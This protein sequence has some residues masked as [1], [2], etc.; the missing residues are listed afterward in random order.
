M[1][2]RDRY[3]STNQTL[4]LASLVKTFMGSKFT[5]HPERYMEILYILQ[6]YRLGDILSHLGFLQESKHTRS[7]AEEHGECAEDLAHALEDLGTC[8]IKLGQVLSTR[9]DLLPT[10]YITSLARLQDTVK[11]VPGERIAAIIERELGAPLGELFLSI[12][13]EPLATASVA[14]VHKALLHDGSQVVIKV[15][16]PEVQRQVEIDIEVMQEVAS[17]L[18]RYTPF[19]ARYGLVQIVQE[20]KQT[21]S[22]ELD[23]QQEASN[24]QLVGRCLQGFDRLKS[25]TVYLD[26]T[27]RRVL[28]LS[29]VQ[30]R[31][32]AQVSRDELKRVDSATIAQEL[33]SA[34]LKQ[35]IVD[36]IFHCD[37]HPGNIL[38][39][40]DGRL[41]LLDFG[42]V[43]RLDAGQKQ[44]VILL[45]LAFAERQGERVADTYLELVQPPESFDRRAFTQGICSLVC[46]YHDM[47]NG[48]MQ[49]GRALLELVE[50]A[51]SYHAPIPASLS[52]LGK[53][54]LNLDSTLHV[55]SPD[56]NPVQVIREYMAQVMHEQVLDQISPIR[57]Y[58]WLLDARH[59][60]ENIPHRADIIS[61]KLAHDR[62]T[63]RLKND[64]LDK[65]LQQAASRI[66]WSMLLSSLMISAGLF[67]APRWHRGRS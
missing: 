43:G 52:L 35:M 18:T 59:L 32:L 20:L 66:S 49:I 28:T 25:P 2:T 62:L 33:F 46:R 27:S 60:A 51:Q 31:H 19:G 11:P 38:L 53:A 10:S 21:L 50:L 61:D 56:L 57:S 64:S 14:Q 23:F 4:P 29:F 5:C 36:G 39:G 6:R 16:R 47:A 44:H 45:L 26:Y 30:G 24:T 9:S 41:A 42:M 7:D 13:W 34:Y 40:D 48:R 37:P 58:T 8:F 1:A 17:F 65:A 55:L 54:M 15:Q 3:T 22:Q 67:F 63:F 12:D